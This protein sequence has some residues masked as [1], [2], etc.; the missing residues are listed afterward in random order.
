MTAFDLI[1]IS[2]FHNSNEKLLISKSV[3]LYRS[4]IHL[5]SIF[6]EITSFSYFAWIFS[7]C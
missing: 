6:E 2:F 4:M 3:E 5:K 1:L 7:F